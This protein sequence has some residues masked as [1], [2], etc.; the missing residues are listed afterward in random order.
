MQGENKRFF[1]QMA[2]RQLQLAEAA[3]PQPLGAPAPVQEQA[4]ILETASRWLQPAEKNNVMHL[5][6]S[7]RAKAR[8]S[9]TACSRTRLAGQKSTLLLWKHSILCW[10]AKHV[11][12][13]GRLGPFVIPGRGS[14]MVVSACAVLGRGSWAGASAPQQEKA[15]T[16]PTRAPRVSGGRFQQRAG[17]V[18]SRRNVRTSVRGE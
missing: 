18:S 10:H 13:A 3:G 8:G 14:G 1:L 9:P 17:S 6:G 2:S 16:C 7:P 12:V 5:F 11:P 15:S 4:F